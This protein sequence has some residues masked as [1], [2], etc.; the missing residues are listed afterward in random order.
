MRIRA[1]LL[2]L[3]VM[4]A[5]FASGA[6]DLN[7]DFKPT[8]ARIQLV[9]ADDSRVVVEATS[10]RPA[11]TVRGASSWTLTFE[12]PGDTAEKQVKGSPIFFDLGSTPTRK[13]SH[14]YTIVR[15]EKRAGLRTW[16]MKLVDDDFF[17]S[18][19][20]EVIPQEHRPRPVQAADGDVTLTLPVALAPGE[21]ALFTDVEAWEFTVLPN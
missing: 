15:L 19:G 14:A 12:V 3:P 21:Y 13:P 1:L 6:G 9:M 8:N 17:P 2:A 4:L 7:W 16:A 11:R 5:S 20:S 18:S 10:A